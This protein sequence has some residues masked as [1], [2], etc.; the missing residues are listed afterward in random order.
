MTLTYTPGDPFLT[1]FNAAK[2]LRPELEVEI[3]WSPAE[4]LPEDGTGEP[5]M[6]R[7]K[8]RDDRPASYLFLANIEVAL[9]DL[10]DAFAYFLTGA[11]LIEKPE[12]DFP[13]EEADT[14]GHAALSMMLDLQ[15]VEDMDLHLIEGIH[16]AAAIRRFPVLGGMSG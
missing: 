15:G 3:V 7:A 6:Y 14:V 2:A 11:I 10:S 12:D 16:Q 5:L 13:E 4:N 1:V 8:M 9:G